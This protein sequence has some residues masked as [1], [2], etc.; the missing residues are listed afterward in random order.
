MLFITSAMAME[1]LN[2]LYLDLVIGIGCQIG[3]VLHLSI[4]CW[5]ISTVSFM[6]LCVLDPAKIF[7]MEITQH[8]TLK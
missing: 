7:P 4:E 8:T 3:A 5:T 2:I 1:G 6:M